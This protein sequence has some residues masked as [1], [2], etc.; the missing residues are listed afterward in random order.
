MRLRFAVSYTAFAILLLLSSLFLYSCSGES[1]QSAAKS[2]TLVANGKSEYVIII[3]QDP[4]SVEQS[5]AEDLKSIIGKMANVQI[6][7]FTDG[8][9]PKAREISI[10]NTNR[11]KSKSDQLTAQGYELRTEGQRILLRG[12]SEV[13][14]RYGYQDLIE[15]LGARRYVANTTIFKNGTELTFPGMDKIYNP[16]F[17]YRQLDYAGAESTFFSDWYKLDNSKVNELWGMHGATLEKLLP[18]TSYFA[19]HP[20]WYAEVNGK[21]I[22]N[23]GLCLSNS[24]VE[25]QV[26]DLLALRIQ[27]NPGAIY[28]SVSPDPAHGMCTCAACSRINEE[29]GSPAGTLIRFL[30]QLSPDF[31]GRQLVAEMSGMYRHAPKTKPAGNVLIVLPADDLD[32]AHPIATADVNAGFRNDLQAWLQ[33]TNQIMVRD[34]L[35]QSSNYISPFPNLRAIQS[36]FQYFRDQG[37]KQI[38]AQGDPE[39]GGELAELRQFVTARLLW[40]PDLQVDSMIQEFCSF[41]YG[42]AGPFVYRYVELLHNQLEASGRPLTSRGSPVEGMD[43]YLRPEYMDQY[44][45]FF[46]QAEPLISN[47][48]QLRDRLQRDRL[49]LVYVSL[50]LA[51]AYGTEKRG[52][53]LN[54]N[55]KWIKVEGLLDLAN[56]F[57][58]ECDR[59]GIKHL[60]EA[61]TTPQAYQTDLLRYADRPVQEHIFFRKSAI[62]FGQSPSPLF[63]GGDPIYLVD[64]ISGLT[65][66]RYSWLGFSGN[67][68]EATMDFGKD[69]VFSSVETHFL[70]DPDHQ[71]VLPTNITISVSFDNANFTPVKT[72]ANADAGSGGGLTIKE[73][74]STFTAQKA[75][76]FKITAENPGTVNGSETPAWLFVDE[77]VVK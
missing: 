67:N 41:Y 20:E 77:I 59:L 72:F 53:Y 33:L 73:F 23:G 25:K 16:P 45:Y 75:R 21:R 10:G 13:G 29:E 61:G 28:W 63:S 47:D 71:I 57:V 65:D 6:P 50:E 56:N 38:V 49:P 3:P 9:A 44:N 17:I 69:T 12:G 11:W 60:N 18:A 5:T 26:R 15:M 74:K 8:D 7:V 4:T 14:L 68:V 19:Q 66:Y 46:N 76:Y 70:Q 51:K 48:P 55:K 27:A 32:H 1:V 37:V 58:V 62:S 35:V 64:G 54:V 22:N 2:V 24:D 52:F 34:Y 40:N 31:T 30:N 42:A 43:T 36:D 39:P